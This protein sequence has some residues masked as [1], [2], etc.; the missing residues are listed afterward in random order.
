MVYL[1]IFS[2][3]WFSR[4]NLQETIEFP[5]D[6]PIKYIFKMVALL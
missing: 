4:G 2:M 6:C 1:S 3:D 5:V